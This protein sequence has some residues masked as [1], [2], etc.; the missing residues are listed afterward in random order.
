MKFYAMSHT[1]T[2]THPHTHTLVKCTLLVHQW[3]GLIS[4]GPHF[5]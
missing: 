3:K 2:H 1:H 5:T 4:P